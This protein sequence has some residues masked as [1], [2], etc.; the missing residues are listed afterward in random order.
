M[1]EDACADVE[2]KKRLLHLARI[3][4][5]AEI[6]IN[7]CNTGRECSLQ[8]NCIGGKVCKLVREGSK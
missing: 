6:M 7:K 8:E 4:A 3:G 2:K 5:E 1:W